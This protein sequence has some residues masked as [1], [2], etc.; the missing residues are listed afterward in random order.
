MPSKNNSLNKVYQISVEAEE[1]AI[2]SFKDAQ[3][4]YQ[5]NLSQLQSLK[6]YR[7]EY[8]QQLNL[9]EFKN[10]TANKYQQIH[11]FIKQIDHAINQ[12]IT[13]INQ[14]EQLKQERQKMV[15]EKQIKR[16]AIEFLLNKNR[17]EQVKAENRQ[18]QQ[19]ADE[20][21]LRQFYL[22]KS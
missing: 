8:T 19:N 15:M 9:P 4:L 1:K 7:L 14:K 11:L 10:V 21:N 13:A 16:K 2:V 12:Q 17:Q 18:E 22:S 5:K 3:V 6:Q 20:F